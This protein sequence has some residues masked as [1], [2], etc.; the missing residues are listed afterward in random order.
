MAFLWWRNLLSWAGSPD[1]GTQK[2]QPDVYRNVSKAD[3]SDD[4]T[5]QISAVFSAI[6]LIAESAGSLPLHVYRRTDDELRERER[7]HRVARLLRDPNEAMTGQE[8]REATL[9][10]LAGWGNAYWLIERANSGAPTGIW[11]LKPERMKVTRD[12]NRGLVYTY[13]TEGGEI[14]YRPGE[15]AHFKGFGTDGI[16]G[17]SPLGMM[18]ESLGLAVAAEEYAGAFFGNGGRPSAVLTFDQ[19]LREEQRKAAKSMVSAMANGAETA[20]KAWVLEGGVKYQSISIPPEDAQMLQTRSFQIQEIARIFRVPPHLLMDSEKS[21]S[22]GSGLEQQNLAFL[23][24]TLR[25]YL[26]RMEQVMARALFSAAERE[27]MTIEHSVEGLLRADSKAR[28]DF[29][30]VMV[31]N[32]LMTRNEVRAKENWQPMA[33]GDVLTAQ[34]NLAPLE[35]LGEPEPDPL[36]AAIGGALD[37]DADETGAD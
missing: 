14:T 6:R 36:A 28:A 3:I 32:G 34:V 27:T 12:G 37:E 16:V 8:L 35:K 1:K 31:Q 9:T 30:S 29:Y 26:V 11:P 2:M 33:G 18:R 25:P 4:R 21:T 15:V 10:S 20:H 17:L 13:T 24:Y 22:W 23:T 5:M 7:G 19:F